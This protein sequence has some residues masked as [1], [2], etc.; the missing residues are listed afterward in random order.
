[1]SIFMIHIRRHEY[2]DKMCTDA[3]TVWCGKRFGWFILP[4][5]AA[6]VFAVLFLSAYAVYAEVLRENTYL[7]RTIKVREGQKVIDTG[8][9][10]IVRHP[11]YSATLLFNRI[12]S[13]RLYIRGTLD[14]IHSIW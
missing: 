7:S 9:Y 12:A 1:M 8:L 3:Y 14:T 11:M 2:I 5:T 13:L 4:K 10:G 6:I